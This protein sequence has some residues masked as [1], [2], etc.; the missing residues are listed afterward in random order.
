MPGERLG[1]SLSTWSCTIGSKINTSS[2]YSI[3]ANFPRHPFVVESCPLRFYQSTK[4][5]YFEIMIDI[6]SRRSHKTQPTLNPDGFSHRSKNSRPRFGTVVVHTHKVILGD[7]PFVSEGLP[8]A[9]DWEVLESSILSVDEY[10]RQ[11]EERPSR[12]FPTKISYSEREE[13]LRS[14]GYTNLHF[15]PVIQE[16]QK[17]KKTR[18]RDILAG[19][20]PGPPVCPSRSP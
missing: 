13:W 19:I 17:I 12:S 5:V 18:K 11:R 14:Q 4:N 2:C 6:A 3:K 1:T 9:L 8:L 20:I 15:I 7:H 16:I 10:E